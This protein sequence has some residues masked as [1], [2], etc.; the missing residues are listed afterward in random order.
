MFDVFTFKAKNE[1]FKFNYLKMNTFK[2][3]QCWKND[4]LVLSMFDK[5]VFNLPPMS[6]FDQNRD[7]GLYEITK[8]KILTILEA[9][10]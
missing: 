1:M 8:V 4:I 5:I 3:V 2:F 9:Q 6:N 10:N 7:S